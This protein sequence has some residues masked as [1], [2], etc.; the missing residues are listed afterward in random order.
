M[1]PRSST[2]IERGG[3]QSVTPRLALVVLFSLAAFFVASFRPLPV[4]TC[5][6]AGTLSA[7][8]ADNDAPVAIEEEGRGQC[9]IAAV[10]PPRD[11]RGQGL[12]VRE[13]PFFAIDASRLPTATRLVVDTPAEPSGS[14]EL[15]P[16]RRVRRHAEVMVFLS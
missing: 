4:S 16:M 15:A 1:R 13:L 7:C 6:P 8:D 9:R 10:R 12:R 11:G 3:G 14:R 5:S 2:A